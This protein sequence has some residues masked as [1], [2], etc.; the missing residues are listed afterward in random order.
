[1]TFRAVLLAAFLFACSGPLAAESARD[2]LTSA[3]F[4]PSNKATALSRV[5][6][7]LKTADAAVARNP[8]DQ[9]ARLQ[10]ALAMSYR[11]KLKR[12]RSDLIASR[13]GF[14][15]AVAADPRN[16][17]AQ[18][19]LACWHLGAIIELGPMMARTMLGARTATGTQALNRALALGSEHASI[20]ALASLHR[21]QLDPADIAGARR[22]AEAAVAAGATTPLDRVMQ[23]QA[24][25][26]LASL[27][28]G[29]GK[30]SA[31]VAKLLLPFGRLR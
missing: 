9:D 31:A 24:A 10:R 21:I 6:V 14:E 1:M 12:S 19:A 15:A 11:G 25:T 29:N 3:A 26:L 28:K 27:R 5:E 17:E 8:R 7:A 2:I 4:S 13:Q 18:M 20:P 23:R 30:T 22:L 16:A